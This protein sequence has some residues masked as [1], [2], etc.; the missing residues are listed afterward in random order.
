[1]RKL[2]REQQKYINTFFDTLDVDG[3]EEV[4]EKFLLCRG[5]IFFAGVGKSGIVAQKIATTL[6]STGTRALTLSPTDALHGDIGIISEDDIVVMISKSG[7][8]DELL[9]L[10]PYIRNKGA[11][12]IGLVSNANSRLVKA[13]HQS[14]CLPLEK[15]LCPYDLVP[16]T[17]SVLQMIF[18]DVLAVAMMEAKKFSL[19]DYAK[20]HPAGRIG[21]RITLKVSDLMVAG[22][23]V[24]ICSADDKLVDVLVKLSDKR[25]GCLVITDDNGRLQGIFTDGDLRRAMQSFGPEVMD[26][27]MGELMESSPRSINPQELAWDAMKIMESDQKHPI[28]VLPVLDGDTGGVV[29]IIK[30]HDIVQSGLV[31]INT[32]KSSDARSVKS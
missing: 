10:I 25:C 27:L 5:V 31:S 15:E 14:V 24:P 8:T 2:F 32:E 30:M 17:S 13:C 4:L 6:T 29:G 18:G 26:K 19:D 23:A 3:A 7:E 21:K 12:I 9:T 16:A 20:N 11:H 22:D 1:M 28:M